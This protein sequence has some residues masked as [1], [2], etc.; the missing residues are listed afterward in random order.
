M[1]IDLSNLRHTHT[2]DV[3]CKTSSDR[4][5]VARSNKMGWTIRGGVWGG[6]SLPQSGVG[7]RENTTLSVNVLT[8]YRLP[9]HASALTDKTF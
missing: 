8:I 9:D 7:S 3:V 1:H 4:S 6:V 5:Y 2:V